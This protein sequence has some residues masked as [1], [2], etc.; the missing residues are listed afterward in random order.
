MAIEIFGNIFQKIDNVVQSEII[1]S[2]SNV[3][4]V[5]SPIMI[6]AFTIYL[7]FVFLSYWQGSGLE[8]TLVDLL[9]RVMAWAVVIGFGANLS[10]YNNT[11]V[12]IVMGL[13]DGLVD[14]FNGTDGSIG[15][16]LDNL[17]AQLVDIVVKNNDKANELPMPFGLGDKI[18]VIFKNAIIIISFGIFL[19]IAGAYIILAK[20]MTAILAV[21]GPIF[22][23]LALFPATRQYFMSWVNQVVNYSLYLVVVNVTASIFIGYLNSDFGLAG[24]EAETETGLVE[25]FLTSLI[26]F[27]VLL[28]LPEL[29]SGLAGGIANTGFGGAIQ[30]ASNMAKGGSAV[31]LASGKARQA[32][33]RGYE[34]LKRR[35]KKGSGGKMEA[36]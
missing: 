8:G 4:D 31:G 22:I 25:V 17:G 13:G 24:I 10:A 27:V 26:F 9:K 16:S 2:V 19:I 12:P 34:A 30:T 5:L 7:L 32:G 20:V 28:K 23:C 21:L 18:A 11:V 33:V 36:S 6:S 3:S 14:L 1:T 15:S 29:A 35:F